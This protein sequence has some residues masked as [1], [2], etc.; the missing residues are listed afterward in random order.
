LV[1]RDES[2]ESSDDCCCERID[3]GFGHEC[4]CCCGCGIAN[5]MNFLF[6]FEFS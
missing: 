5:A 1:Q 4:G 6:V 2:V 3:A